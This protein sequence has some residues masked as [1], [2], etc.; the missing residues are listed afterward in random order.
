M[1]FE[2]FVSHSVGHDDTRL[3]DE[4]ERQAK[5]LG[6]RFYLAERDVQPGSPLSVK[7]RNAI[8]RADLVVA[9]LTKQ[10]ATSP[11]VNQEIGF[12]RQQ[13]KRIVPLLEDGV[14]P[15]GIIVEMEQVRFRR[16]RP[17]EAL[18]LVTSYLRKMKS[19][20]EFW[21]GVGIAAGAAIAIALAIYILSKKK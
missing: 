16:D 12:A 7:I 13:N 20:K 1:S 14:K 3:L 9:L 2:V 18:E 8:V 6:I 4:L 21:V 15:P 17:S 10:G 19:N 5:T 11:W